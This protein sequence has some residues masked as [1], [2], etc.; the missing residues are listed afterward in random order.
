M[1]C[2]LPASNLQIHVHATFLPADAVQAGLL[3]S[4]SALAPAFPSLRTVATA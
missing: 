1:T 3:A 2:L 4:G